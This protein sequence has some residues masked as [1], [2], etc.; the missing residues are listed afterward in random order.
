MNF[1][2]GECRASSARKHKAL[3]MIKAYFD[4]SGTHGQS[5]ITM[6]AGFFAPANVWDAFGAD[7]SQVLKDYRVP[8]FH[9]SVCEAGD[10][11]YSWMDR[12]LRHLLF[13]A[14]A[15]VICNH[16]PIGVHGAIR[17]DVWRVGDSTITAQAFANPYYPCFD[18]CLQTMAFWSQNYGN[19]ESIALI[20]AE[21]QDYKA[22]ALEMYDLYCADA[23]WGKYFAS[24]TFAPANDF[25]ALQAADLYAYEIF[26][27][28]K[29][30]LKNK[31]LSR[32][33]TQVFGEAKLLGF[34]NNYDPSLF[35]KIYKAS[36]TK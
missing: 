10:E 22:K 5:H 27:Q 15:K 19:E 2:F 34:G 28:S 6:M 14:A 29:A 18:H 7:W 11:P 17:S 3:A 23:M 24:I 31:M 4:E 35:P 33:A 30:N 25:P 1:G 36:I 21:Q 16:R 9:A 20:F 32:P 8:Y 13:T 26:A 12:T